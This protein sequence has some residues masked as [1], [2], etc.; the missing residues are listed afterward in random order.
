MNSDLDNRTSRLLER[1]NKIGVEFL[2]TDLNT[3]LT[4]VEV[5]LTTNSPVNRNRNIES[6][7]EVYR[8][9]TRLLP[10]V[11][12]TPLEQMEIEQKL[13]D[14]RLRIREAGY[15]DKI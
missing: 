13:E 11:V 5:A 15:P 4:F 2:L 12:P 7:V 14:L 8:T 10:R 1:S 6:A 9:V 3:G